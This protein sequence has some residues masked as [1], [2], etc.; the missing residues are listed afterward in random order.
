MYALRES[1]NAG[2]NKMIRRYVLKMYQIDD[3]RATRRR[4]DGLDIVPIF[5]PIVMHRYLRVCTYIQEK[6]RPRGRSRIFSLR[7]NICNSLEPYRN[8]IYIV[9][10]HSILLYFWSAF[11]GRDFCT[12]HYIGRLS[13][14]IKYSFK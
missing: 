4:R 10:Y 7:Q 6:R 14:T 13:R 8:E 3:P 9:F 11:D 1:R 2:I 5:F 12:L